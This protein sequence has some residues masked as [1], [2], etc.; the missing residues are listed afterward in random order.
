[1]S[2]IHEIVNVELLTKSANLQ[3]PNEHNVTQVEVP[4][5]DS[6]ELLQS[7]IVLIAPTKPA[8]DGLLVGKVLSQGIT[9]GPAEYKI[10]ATLGNADPL[11]RTLYSRLLPGGISSGK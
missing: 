5:L 7:R 11:V 9:T 2:M 3:S 1:M 4:K 8:A 10:I 6:A